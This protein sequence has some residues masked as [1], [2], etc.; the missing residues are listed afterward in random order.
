MGS[1]SNKQSQEFEYKA[2]M[3]QLLNLIVHSLYTHPEIF[4]RELVS[5]SSDALNKFR[6]RRLTE[7][8]VLQPESE[9]KISITLDKENHLFTIEDT[10]IGMTKDDLV[11][12][13][14]TIAS[15]GTIQ[16]LNNL[17]DKNQAIDGNLIG[18]FGVGFYSVF[19]VTDE[20]TIET[21]NFA[22]DSIAYRWTSK[23]EDKF[24]IEEIEREERGTKIQFKLKEEF[25]EYSE[26][27]KVQSVLKKYSNFVDFEIYVNNEKV[28]SVQALWHKKKEDIN[29]EQLNEFY[30]F[31]TNDFDTPL[32]HLHLNIEGNV[33]FKALLFVPKHAPPMMFRDANEKSL[34]LYTN[35]VFITD[36]NKD[37]LPEYL[38]FIKGVLD[39]E[40][41][42]L[43]VSR[44]VVQSSP[45]MAKIKNVLVSRILQMLEEWA[46]NDKEKYK[47]FYKEFGSLL[48]AGIN[49]DYSNRDKIIDLLRF[50]SSKTE[51]DE[52]TSFKRYK[53]KMRP[54]QTDIF[55]V[56]GDNRIAVDRNPNLEYFKKHDIEVLYLT[57]PVDL[58]TIPYIFD[59]QGSQLKSID[60][61]DLKIEKTETTDKMEDDNT[62]K[63]ISVFKE[64]LS[65]QVEDVRVSDRLVESP[66][67]LVV[68]SQGLDPQMEKM[69]KM[70]EKE[71][72]ASKR[73]LEINT[74]H[75]LIKNLYS[76][77]SSDKDSLLLRNCILQIFE[78]ALLLEG[79][80]KSPVDFQKRMLEIMLEAT[81]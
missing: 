81:K 57:D 45:H 44:E 37:I 42:P 52:Y 48:K 70:M 15:S 64:V 14:G 17:K 60:K 24:T 54:D 26:D 74:S 41:L 75:K 1:I 67:T 47:E 50:E 8:N 21:R 3:K 5:N 19:M 55:Y 27:Y 63:L 77:L 76:I 73:I 58:F 9:L 16:F 4:I 80:L 79:Y 13:I 28:N 68:G 31:L 59:Y 61:A 51:N 35:K 33:N 12:Q 11:N 43:N 7:Q 18:Q 46:S 30:K 72:N 32:G 39:T 2:E 78:G 25:K 20:V 53:A 34:N 49:S 65:E 40:D 6:F 38:R 29:E 36:D 69:M 71:F 10:G 22:T 56:S 23:G 66:A 62:E